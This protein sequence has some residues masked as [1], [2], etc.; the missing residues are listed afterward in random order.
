MPPLLTG[1]VHAFVAMAT[2]P[3]RWQIAVCA[4]VAV[5]STDA[6]RD[7]IHYLDDLNEDIVGMKGAFSVAFEAFS[8]RGVG[9][10]LFS[11]SSQRK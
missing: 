8:G 10:A 6:W 4:G 9:S 7:L 11:P 3:L 2:T 5:P 1:N